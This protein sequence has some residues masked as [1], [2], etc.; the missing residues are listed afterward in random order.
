MDT[1]QKA[2]GKGVRR[3]GG[4]L[5]LRVVQTGPNSDIVPP[6]MRQE[7][8][9]TVRIGIHHYGCPVSTCEARDSSVTQA[10]GRPSGQLQEDSPLRGRSYVIARYEPR[11]RQ[12][13]HGCLY[14]RGIRSLRDRLADSLPVNYHCTRS[15]LAC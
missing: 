3:I 4:A 10:V 8:T 6:S 5:H 15:Q 2:L 14:G 13:V 7:V 1:R 9:G 11:M 12:N